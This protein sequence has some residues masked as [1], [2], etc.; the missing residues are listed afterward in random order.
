VVVCTGPS[1]P[2]AVHVTEANVPQSHAHGR[3]KHDPKQKHCRQ[4][5]EALK[6]KGSTKVYELF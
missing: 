3:L 2:V 6:A 5:P 4:N 1:S